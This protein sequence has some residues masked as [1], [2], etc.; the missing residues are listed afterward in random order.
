MWEGAQFN[1]SGNQDTVTVDDG[2]LSIFS[3]F[4]LHGKVEG[5]QNH[6]TTT[7]QHTSHHTMGKARKKNRTHAKPEEGENP[8]AVKVPKTFVMRSG[9]VGSSVMGLVG[10]IRRLME[11]NT[12][13]KLR[14]RPHPS[15][16]LLQPPGN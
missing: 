16:T 5:P 6:L 3:F 9:E 2:G 10:D 8:N 13:T 15:S 7:H 1:F 4:L 11:P 14:V 12:A